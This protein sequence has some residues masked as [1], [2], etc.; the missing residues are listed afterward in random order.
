MTGPVNLPPAGF[1]GRQFVDNNGCIF[2]RAGNGDGVNWVPRVTRQRQVICG[3]TPS[4]ATVRQPALS[5][6]VVSAAA[7]RVPVAHR[8]ARQAAV[9]LRQVPQ[10]YQPAW[11]DGRLNP[12]RGPRSREGDLQSEQ[13]W[14]NTVPRR[15]LR[16]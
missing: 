3:H 15:L 1:E 8:S 11:K 14:T 10:G 9:D 12:D 5:N 16:P 13:V 2:V 4:F 7:G 6:T